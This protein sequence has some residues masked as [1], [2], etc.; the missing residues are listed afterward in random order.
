ML[1]GVRGVGKTTTARLIARALNC[2]GADGR[3]GPT[4]DP[5]GVCEPCLA[6]AEARHVD[7]IEMD[8]ASRTGIDDVREMIEGVRYRA[9]A[10]RAYKIYII[11]E[12][13]ML[14]A[15]LQRLAEDT[16]RAARTREVFLRH[17]R[18]A[19]GA[20]HGAVALPALRPQAVCRSRR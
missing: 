5:C 8:A 3:G 18:A 20:G 2:I 14:S 13:H 16:G 6:I 12:V 9:R 4:V 10:L 19:E 11:D 7:V 15:G 1:T 17:H